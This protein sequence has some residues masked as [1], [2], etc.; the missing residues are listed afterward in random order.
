VA[1]R[2]LQE[3]A[4]PE[5]LP[6]GAIGAGRAG[7]VPVLEGLG[8]CRQLVHLDERRGL[9]AALRLRQR[10]RWGEG[11]AGGGAEGQYD[12]FGRHPSSPQRRTRQERSCESRR[13]AARARGAAQCAPPPR[14]SGT[15]RAA[16]TWSSRKLMAPIRAVDG[17]LE[18]VAATWADLETSAARRERLC[19]G[20]RRRT[21]STYGRAGPCS[22]HRRRGRPVAA[23]VLHTLARRPPS[24]RL[25]LSAL[26]WALS[27][28]LCMAVA[29]A[30]PL[31]GGARHARR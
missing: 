27:E 18:P 25:D 1:A 10:A 30:R 20:S 11:A 31:D 28:P 29:R 3:A 26:W 2:R 15:A 22:L 19:Y 8:L 9:G 6:L 24:V 13:G 21:A 23:R 4:Q 12:A 14:T 17:A 7:R 5:A 16:A